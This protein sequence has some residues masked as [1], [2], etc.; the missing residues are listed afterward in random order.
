MVGLRRL[1]AGSAGTLLVGM[2]AGFVLASAVGVFIQDS[3]LLVFAA[4]A[5]GAGG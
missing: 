2:F 3:G 1:I 4:G 5:L